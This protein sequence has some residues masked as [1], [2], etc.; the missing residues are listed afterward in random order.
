MSTLSHLG[1][2][3]SIIR[4]LDLTAIR[5]QAEAP[6]HLAVLGSDREAVHWLSDALRTS[7]FDET[8]ASI[9]QI[10][11][12][13]RLPA[14]PEAV[15]E[16][17]RADVVLLVL[18]TDQANVT[19]EQ[20]TLAQLRE[21]SQAVPI[22][23]VHIKGFNAAGAA[24]EPPADRRL[25]RVDDEAIVDVSAR[26]P[27]ESGLAPA[28]LRFFGG[29]EVALGH[30]VPATR[31]VIARQLIAETSFA[32]ASYSTTTGIA[33]IIPVLNIPF[34]IAD[35]FVLTKNQIILSYKLALALGHSGT[36]QELVGPVAGVIG[37]SFIWRSVA[38]TLA[39]LIP[40]IGIVPKVA[41][42]YS[43]TYVSGHAV[44]NWYAHGSQLD[45]E[46]MK[47][48]TAEAAAEAKVRTAGLLAA[49]RNRRGQEATASAP[50]AA[51]RRFLS[52]P[53]RGARCPNCQQKVGR[54]Q[55]YCPN[56]GQ[57]IVPLAPPLPTSSPS[58]ASE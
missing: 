20:E 39:G 24:L 47:A 4:E 21:H 28:L 55:R 14:K 29:R 56:C 43:G 22:I 58:S 49:V 2:V 51:R 52:L 7:P 30:H 53:D 26:Q 36:T 31:A 32:S 17:A 42:S 1:N 41:I 44:Y 54:K 19:A 15:A 16:A 57:P 8:L 45:K 18:P 3:W 25:W 38:R 35:I 37:G 5:Q 34:T 27:L 48:L 50:K 13:Y 10:L 11:W 46:R 33:E 40:G 12:A 23:A 6:V 9:P